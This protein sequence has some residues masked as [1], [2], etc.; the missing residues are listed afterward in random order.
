MVYH[1]SGD[2]RRARK[3]G[4]ELEQ[5]LS[6]TSTRPDIPTCLELATLLFAVGVKQAPSDLLSYLVRNNHDNPVLQDEIQGIFDKANLSDEGLALIN[7]ARKEASEIMNKGVLLWKSG[8]LDD[9]IG[10]MRNARASL[11]NNLRILFNSA[12][13]LITK[14]QQ[15]GY[16]QALSQEAITVLLHV[17]NIAPGQLRF[18]Q[19]MEQ[20][21][22][23][24]PVTA[25][26]VPVAAGAAAGADSGTAGNAETE[27]QNQAKTAAAAAANH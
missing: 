26:V 5:M 20:L 25:E 24:T 13:I 9:A 17:D 16:D 23:L 2:Y 21:A 3:C 10:W 8:K 6:E 12:Q 7:T 14:M 19:L 11:P 18:A 15:S 1:E 22:G 27:A 4:D